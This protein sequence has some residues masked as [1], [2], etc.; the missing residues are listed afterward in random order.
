MTQATFVIEFETVN[1]DNTNNF[2]DAIIFYGPPACGKGTQARI[3]AKRLPQYQHFD[4]GNII[5]SFINKYS[6]Y[7]NANNTVQN[8]KN[9]DQSKANFDDE[10]NN[11][12]K[13]EQENIKMAERMQERM[14]QG[15]AVQ[16]DDLWKLIDDTLIKA[17]SDNKK[18]LI[19][20]I[21][22]TIGDGRRF[23]EFC[24]KHNLSV[25]IFHMYIS[26]NQS[27][28]R[29]SKRYYLEGDS[30]PYYG[31]QDA[32]DHATKTQKPY[33]RTDDLNPEAIKSRY[34]KLYADIF[35]K[36][37]ATIQIQSHGRLFVVDGMDK[38]DDIANHIWNY[39]TTFYSSLITYK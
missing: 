10:I 11:L 2:P 39:L 33:Q 27:I 20:G 18:L 31:M 5:R 32:L 9:T 26:E 13:T 34:H 19:E 17:L 6:K 28:L 14:N 4:F 12:S 21:G 1:L 35:A 36:T 7:I 29:A 16:I 3:L 15:L 22:R 23:G 38:I 24:K 30:T 37:M 25:A 8:S